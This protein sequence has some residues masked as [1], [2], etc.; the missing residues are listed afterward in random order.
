MA[1][2]RG[3]GAARIG[4]FSSLHYGE[5]GYCLEVAHITGRHAEAELQSG[6][7]DQQIFKS[8]CHAPGGLVALDSPGQHSRFDGDRISGYVPHQFIDESLPT[9][10]ALFCHRALNA[11]G[12]FHN[13]NHGDADL[14]FAIAGSDLLQYLPD[15][16]A[17]AITTLESRR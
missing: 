11:V 2:G 17:P 10:P 14:D 5:T 15:R 16:V 6:C 12:Q 13:S 4:L 3:S 8:D 7:R 1:S 9:A